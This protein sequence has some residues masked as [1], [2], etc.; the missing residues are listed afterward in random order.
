[1]EVFWHNG[2]HATSLPD[3][4]EGMG[5]T[6]GSIYKAYDDKRSIYLAALDTFIDM[7]L[8]RF[9]KILSKPDKRAAIREALR[10][11]AKE[12]ASVSGQKGCFSTAATIEMVPVD[13]DVEARL[14]E[15]YASM[16]SSLTACIDAGKRDGSITSSMPS[17]SLARLLVC[18]LEGMAVLGKLGPTERSNQKFTNVVMTLLD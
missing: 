17:G 5:L 7:R 1:M 9:E 14:Y 16:E 3:L 10:V 13:A 18:T 8:E 12:T 15:L 6:R 2:F 4:I 11:A